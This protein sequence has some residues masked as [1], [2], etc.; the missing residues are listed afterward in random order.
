MNGSR[1]SRSEIRVLFEMINKYGHLTY[2]MTQELHPE[3]LVK[4]NTWRSSG[5]M[6]QAAYRIERGYYDHL[7]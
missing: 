6:Y 4:T 7:I 3:Y 2:A 1:Y 5:A